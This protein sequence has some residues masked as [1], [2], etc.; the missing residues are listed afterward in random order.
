MDAP[1]ILVID[2]DPKN[3]QILKESLESSNFRVT[4]CDNGNQ[5]WEI[6]QTQ[7]PDIIVSEVDIPGLNGLE[8]L[9]KIQK[10]PLVAS[11]PLVFLTNRR[12]IE[13]RLKSLRSG[14]KDYMIKPLHVKEV[15]ARLQMILRRID[16]LRHEESESNKKVVGRLEEKNAESLVEDYGLQRR[17]GVL[18]LYD[19]NN[20]NGEIYF[21]DGAVVNARLGNFKAEKAVYQMLPWNRGHFV[22]DFREI[23]IKDEITVSN[24]G[25]LVQGVKQLQQRADLL[26]HLPELDAVFVR[27]SIFEQILKRKTIAP[28]ALKFVALFD[29][30]RTLMDILAEST[31]D[32]IKTLEKI[33]KLHHQGFIKPLNVEQGV[34]PDKASEATIT[35]PVVP[36]IDQ[37]KIQHRVPHHRLAG[38]VEP[39]SFQV[40]EPPKPGANG[41]NERIF[42]PEK[43]RT[44]VEATKQVMQQFLTP[45]GKAAA[46][47]INVEPPLNNSGIKKEPAV[48][49]IATSK[50]GII[51]DQLFNGHAEAVGRFVV[52]S[53]DIISRKNLIAVLSQNNFLSKSLDRNDSMSFEFAKIVTPSQH[54]IEIFGVS[55]ERRFLQMLEQLSD[56]LIGYVVLIGDQNLSN[57]GYTGYLIDSLKRQFSV[58]HIIVMIQSNRK[59]T[60]PLDVVRYTLK[61]EEKEQLLEVDVRDLESV[62]HL[63]QQL[64]PPTAH[65]EKNSQN[66]S[67]SSISHP[68]SVFRN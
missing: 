30:H 28:D 9:E 16:R 21:R 44:P 23:S 53:A 41:L 18:T 20:R 58:P 10:D 38:Q 19:Q 45:E 27:T 14:V 6:I 13:D 50:F 36:V 65:H 47:E 29:G 33:I 49:K 56:T 42:L 51:F 4:V 26:K 31:F 43:P 57:L 68:D 55:T 2:G 48:S 35:L 64:E 66:N 15:I 59:R 12:N 34:K 67:T 54:A 7:R 5:A 40:V 39:P 22:M 11:I 8:L 1:N 46:K 52:V 63:L 25:L 61:L 62:K 17:T 24:L 60:I 32:D 37:K 3:L